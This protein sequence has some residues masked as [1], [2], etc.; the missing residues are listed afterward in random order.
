MDT[1]LTLRLDGEVIEKAKRYAERRGTSL[2]RIVEGYFV[3]LADSDNPSGQTLTGV[4]A[5]LAGS[6][7]GADIGNAEEDYTE[8]L[9]KKYS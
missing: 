9:S 1:K 8:Y 5:E 7:A 4:V 3:R 6:Y 2:S